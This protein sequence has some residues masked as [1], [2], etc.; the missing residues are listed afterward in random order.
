MDRIEHAWKS[1]SP[2]RF[3]DR[4]QPQR[5]C[6]SFDHSIFAKN[7]ERVLSAE[8]ARL[9]FI[10]I[11]DLSRAE[12]W[13]SHAHFTADGTLIESWASPLSYRWRFNGTD[14]PNGTGPVLTLSNL[15]ASH[16]GNYD[17]V[18]TNLAG[19]LTST[20]APLLIFSH[21]ITDWL[22]YTNATIH[23]G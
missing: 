9:F 13:T 16:A 5:L 3:S 15:N 4:G 1:S 14:V 20:V 8:V 22:A 17:V 12:G 6:G 7:Y 23:R 18:V 21:V 19:A 2:A 11:Y 10:E